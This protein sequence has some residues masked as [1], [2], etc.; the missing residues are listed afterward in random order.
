MCYFWHKKSIRK[1]W[2]GCLFN[3][4]HIT[5]IYQGFLSCVHSAQIY[6]FIYLLLHLLKFPPILMQYGKRATPTF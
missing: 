3:P 1:T 5:K 6:V 2:T 4:S